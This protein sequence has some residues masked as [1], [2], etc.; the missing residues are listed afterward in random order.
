MELPFRAQGDQLLPSGEHTDIRRR[1]RSV[2]A[3]HDLTAVL[4]YAFDH[5]TRMLP[6]FFIDLRMVPAGVRAVGSALVD[7]GFE[8]CRIVLQQWN[9][10]FQPSQ[11]R[12]DGR[13]PDLLLISSMSLHTAACKAM[14]RDINKIEPQR[15]PLVIVGGSLCI[16]ESW[17]VFD[18]GL[19]GG[20]AAAAD[21][22]VTG[23][24]YVLLNLLEVLLSDRASGE[25]LR[26][27]FLRARDSGV[28]NAIPGLVYPRT[29]SAG[30]V[31]ELVD[32]GIQRL[33]GDLDELP[34][35]DAGYSILQPPSKLAYLTSTPLPDGEVL[36]HNRVGSLV[37]TFGCKFSCEY[38]PIPAYNQ[39]M[40]RGKSAGRIGEE[41]A[42]LFGRYGIRHFFGTDDNFFSDKKRALS[43]IEMLA[44]NERDGQPLRKRIRWFTEVTVHDTLQMREHLPLIH[45]SGVRALWLGVED[46]SGALVKK[47]QSADRTC[48][49]FELLR[50]NNICPMPMMMHHDAQ[51]ILAK[52][53]G[54]LNQ[55]HALR[56]AGA[57]S[58]Q[59]LMLTPSAGSKS[60]E[61]TFRSG[62]VYESVAGR[63]VEPHMYDGNYVIASNHP[64]SW[65]RQLSIIAAYAFFYNPLRFIGSMM[66]HKGKLGMK[67]AVMQIVGMIG[68]LY[69]IWHTIGWTLRLMLGKIVRKTDTP[70][71]RFPMRA[72]DGGP[73]SHA[74]GQQDTA[75]L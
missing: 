22:A 1:L 2:A 48:E 16:Y 19:P 15:R 56:K 62:M 52:G 32:T 42:R 43:I 65:R 39:H 9:K 64:Q 27:V 55:V 3:R 10:N 8:K 59:V 29:N 23:E 21:L 4:A 28:L 18:A 71:S 51:P 34:F 5:R 68:L 40:L 41:T 25:P 44:S 7:S 33:L 35:P 13:V 45:R 49:A 53:T 50:S 12:I 30:E 58:L 11:A 54:L 57:A 37:M 73:A 24:D 75:G 46:M 17:E 26:Q 47:G 38:C 14:I 36:K 70:R 67:P 31:L 20:P 74:M 6:F 61:R 60:Y 69:T 72:V 63:M 66:H